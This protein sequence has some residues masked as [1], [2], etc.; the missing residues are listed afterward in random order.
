M[1]P[2]ARFNNSTTHLWTAIPSR[3]V[4]SLYAEVSVGKLSQAVRSAWSLAF[5]FKR[6]PASEAVSALPTTKRTEPSALQQSISVEVAP[7]I[8]ITGSPVPSG[9]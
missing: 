5:A 6:N 9:R 1:Y 7:D 4:N 3:K 8:S 2:R